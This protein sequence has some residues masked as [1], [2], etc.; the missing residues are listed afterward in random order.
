MSDDSFI[1]EVDDEL[2]QDTLKKLWQAYGLY[3]IGAAVA[4]VL[5]TAAWT[6]WDYWQRSLANASGDLY[7]EALDL[8]AKGD[9]DGA[10]KALEELEKTGHGAYP[11]LA[12]LRDAMLLFDKGDKAGAVAG[13]DAVA[14]DAS[15]PQALRDMA[16]LRAAYILVDSGSGADVATRAEALASDTNPLRHSAREALGL[17]A[18]KDGRE[19]DAVKLFTQI[20]DDELAP[21]NARQRARLMTELINGSGGPD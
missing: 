7:S 12:R 19:A 13:F 2:R 14:A 17:A 6:G 1:R 9:H 4:I 5:A 11:V 10:A 15:V 21:Q 3:V 18:Y 16:S 8:A 20:A